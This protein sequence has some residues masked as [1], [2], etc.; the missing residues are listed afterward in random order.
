MAKRIIS[1]YLAKR[2]RNDFET[3]MNQKGNNNEANVGDSK[4]LVNRDNTSFKDEIIT[5]AEALEVS[6]SEFKSRVAKRSNRTIQF[7]NKW[8]REPKMLRSIVENAAMEELHEAKIQFQIREESRK[9]K[10]KKVAS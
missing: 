7:V 6:A 3:K 2:I 9:S 4:A 5:R 1:S 8:F 10:L